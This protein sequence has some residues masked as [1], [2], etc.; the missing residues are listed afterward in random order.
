MTHYVLDDFEKFKN[1]QTNLILKKL[2]GRDKTIPFGPQ[3]VV[4]NH[5]ECCGEIM[6]CRG[7]MKGV[8]F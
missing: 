5:V 6:L 2:I 3:N 1:R 8:P 4:R 7:D